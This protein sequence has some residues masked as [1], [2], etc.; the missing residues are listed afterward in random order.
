MC[1]DPLFDLHGRPLT[2]VNKEKCEQVAEVYR[3]EVQARSEQVVQARKNVIDNLCTDVFLRLCSRYEDDVMARVTESVNRIVQ[4][5][6][7]GFH[8]KLKCFSRYTV[9]FC[10]LHCFHYRYGGGKK[11]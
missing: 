1:F 9:V 6:L 5:N 7:N 2:F 3:L 11:F 8:P 10:E 4:Q